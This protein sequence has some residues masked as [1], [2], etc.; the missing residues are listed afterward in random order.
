MY[1][2]KIRE[3]RILHDL[4]QDY[5]ASKLG[6]SQP[7]YSRLENGHR[8]VRI[9]DFRTL[10][11][12]YDVSLPTLMLREG[13]MMYGNQILP[14]A[15]KMKPEPAHQ[16]HYMLHQQEQLISHLL[17]KQ[18]EAE[19]HLQSILRVIVPNGLHEG[20]VKNGSAR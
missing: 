13:D 11:S 14:G 1:Y 4:K 5:V 20:S 10:S 8:H 18:Q 19:E 6:M 3:M 9:E 7:E 17:Q 12:L 2:P 15:A 16:L